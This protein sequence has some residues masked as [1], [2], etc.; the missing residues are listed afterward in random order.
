MTDKQDPG[1][2]KKDDLKSAGKP[3]SETDK[4]T[5]VD[6]PKP[7]KTDAKKPA[8]T[9][10]PK[11]E[12]PKAKEPE[13][14]KPE[15]PKPVEPPKPTEPPK[16]KEPEKPKAEPPKP[17]EPPKAKEPEKPKPE[18]PKPAEPP[19]A[20]EPE[21]PKPEPPKPAEPPKPPE[22]PKPKP[23]KP[24]ELPAEPPK[25][26]EPEPPPVPSDHYAPPDLEAEKVDQEEMEKAAIAKRESIVFAPLKVIIIL[27]SWALM[28]G[29]LYSN[30]NAVQSQWLQVG[31]I[32]APAISLLATI[33]LWKRTSLLFK[34][35]LA[36]LLASLLL[37]LIWVLPD[38]KTFHLV[39]KGVSAAWIMQGYFLGLLFCTA[40]LG[41]RIP[42][43]LKPLAALV[44]LFVLYSAYPLVYGFFTNTSLAA[45]Y[46]GAPLTKSFPFWLQ[47]LYILFEIAVPLGVVL[48]LILFFG[49]LV[50]PGKAQVYLWVL[51]V[52]LAGATAGFA[53]L[54]TFTQKDGQPVP[55]LLAS[56][57]IRSMLY[58]HAM[59]KGPAPKPV[60]KPVKPATP[61][62][63]ATKPVVT[64]PK[65]AP[66][67]PKPA[68]KPAP[69]PAAKPSATEIKKLKD[70]I[71]KQ[72]KTI[73]QLK[74]QIQKLQKMVA[75]MAAKK[76]K[77]RGTG[78]EPPK[79]ATTPKTEVKP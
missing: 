10:K 37:L 36:A 25:K 50:K 23:V 45:L 11:A 73:E 30:W 59:A 1:D 8:E 53:G 19:K 63:P 71:S 68:V 77:P 76:K 75:D 6:R 41:S 46:Q 27:A 31:F 79:P 48:A 13:K 14:P 35:G 52:M 17:A 34:A 29:A 44:M 47:P 64:K 61:P 20:K 4:P 12:P 3:K 60:V 40:V 32:V 62:K 58:A 67:A 2:N 72:S 42:F 55:H 26:M 28:A 7:P 78:A 22:P 24:T 66:P 57:Q 49:N 69:K 15:P 43:M 16:A 18:P 54:N 39:D 9:D 56:P 33:L 5:P 51:L 38:G 70:N 21:K 74:A 65:P